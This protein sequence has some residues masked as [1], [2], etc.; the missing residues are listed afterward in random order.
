MMYRAPR[1]RETSPPLNKRTLR[2]IKSIPRYANNLK[3]QPIEHAHTDS[4]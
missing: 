1:P 2:G 3:Y 4:R